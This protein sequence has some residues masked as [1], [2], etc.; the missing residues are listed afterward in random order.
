MLKL[1]LLVAWLGE[2][3]AGPPFRDPL[4]VIINPA[5]VVLPLTVPP[6]VVTPPPKPAG[7]SQTVW[8]RQTR[9]SGTTATCKLLVGSE[10]V[11]DARGEGQSQFC[12]RHRLGSPDAA[13]VCDGQILALA[14]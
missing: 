9:P 11:A 2:V 7:E 5:P 13:S 3:Q 8:I 6:V 1:L 10:L 4:V 14:I 12:Q